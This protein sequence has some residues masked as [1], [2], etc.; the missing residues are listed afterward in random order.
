MYSATAWRPSLSWVPIRTA[1]CR[2][3]AEWRQPR[4]VRIAG[5]LTERAA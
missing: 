2:L 5:P 1:L 3:K 4:S